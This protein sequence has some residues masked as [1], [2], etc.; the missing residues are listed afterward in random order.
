MHELRGLPL[1]GQ[2]GHQDMDITCLPCLC[3]V[4]CFWGWSH[5]IPWEKT[6]G[7][8][9]LVYHFSLS[10]ASTI[11]ERSENLCRRSNSDLAVFAWVSWTWAFWSSGSLLVISFTSTTW[12]FLPK[13]VWALQPVWSYTLLSCTTCCGLME[14]L[15]KPHSSI[16]LTLCSAWSVLLSSLQTHEIFWLYIYVP[17]YNLWISWEESL[18]AANFQFFPQNVTAAVSFFQ[19]KG[20]VTLC[21]NTRELYHLAHLTPTR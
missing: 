7:P 8:W 13:K 3:L 9:P 5:C 6:A 15:Q 16:V 14:L 12:K 1:W 4:F 20:C 21:I 2:L 10:I 17:K 18:W 19:D 11:S